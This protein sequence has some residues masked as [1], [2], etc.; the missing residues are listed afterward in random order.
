MCGALC[1]PAL[2]LDPG[3]GVDEGGLVD[4]SVVPVDMQIQRHIDTYLDIAVVPAPVVDEHGDGVDDQQQQQTQDDNLLRYA[5][6]LMC[7]T[8]PDT[9][10]VY[11]IQQSC[12][13]NFHSIWRKKAPNMAFKLKN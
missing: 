4:I 8:R 9:Q 6:Y 11:S 2:L 10:I 3:G 1:L 13:Q 7:Q 5:A 12:Q